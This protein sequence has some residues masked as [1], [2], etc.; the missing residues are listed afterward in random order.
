MTRLAKL[1]PALCGLLLIAA[2]AAPPTSNAEGSAPAAAERPVPAT[3]APV[4]SKPAPEQVPTAP[5]GRSAPTTPAP[6]QSAPKPA[7]A[8]PVRVD[9]SCR[10]DADCTVKNVGNC[11]G[12]YPACVNVNSPTDPAAVQAECART[13]RAGVCGFPA[14]SACQCVSGACQAQ[15]NQLRIPM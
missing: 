12:Y 11:C 14:I 1:L 4:A 9:Q 13:G 6:P 2:C 8:T 10:V 5:I 7:V 3:P 15:A